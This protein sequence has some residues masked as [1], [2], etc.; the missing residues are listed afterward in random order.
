VPWSEPTCAAVTSP[1]G[2][3]DL[4]AP[5]GALDLQDARAA[6]AEHG[7]Q[8]VEEP[9]VGQRAAQVRLLVLVGLGQPDEHLG[10]RE[11]VAHEDRQRQELRAGGARLV[12][13]A[14]GPSIIT[15]T[16]T[17][18]CAARGRARAPPRSAR[19]QR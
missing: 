7:A 11:H 6:E 10:G 2:E 18:P 4:A 16:R 15:G 9:V 13:H 3:P 14:G 17:G 8:E 19:A 12:T 5:V 1:D